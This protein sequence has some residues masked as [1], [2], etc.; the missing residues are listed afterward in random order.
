MLDM[1]EKEIIKQGQRDDKSLYFI[2]KGDCF[3]SVYDEGTN[4]CKTSILTEGSHFGEISLIY[5]HERS[6]TVQ[7]RSFA[8]LGRLMRN[9][10]R[11]LVLDYPDF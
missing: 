2:I 3:V 6:A 4:S 8:T 11:Q 10:F 9:N 7:S 5:G 1:P